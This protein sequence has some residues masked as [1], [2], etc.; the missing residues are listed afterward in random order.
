MQC[1]SCVK[2]FSTTEMVNNALNV[3]VWR[4][5]EK[6][7]PNVAFPRSS[8]LDLAA[9]RYPYDFGPYNITDRPKEEREQFWTDNNAAR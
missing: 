1:K 9:Y 7:S 4:G 6:S 8:W 3:N 5:A 2:G